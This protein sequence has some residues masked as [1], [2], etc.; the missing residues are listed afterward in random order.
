MKAKLTQSATGAS[1]GEGARNHIQVIANSGI[2]SVLILLHY[3]QLKKEG[4]LESKGLCFNRNKSD[5][6]VVGIVAYA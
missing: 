6:L 5:V 3:W 1:G 4:R 2:A